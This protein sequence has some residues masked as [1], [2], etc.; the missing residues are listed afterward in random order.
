MF[1]VA[2]E[3]NLQWQKLTLDG[4]ISNVCR[5]QKGHYFI[6]MNSSVEVDKE[7]SLTENGHFN[8]EF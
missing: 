5:F 8:N 6:V 3:I 7:N 2:N 1:G 4:E